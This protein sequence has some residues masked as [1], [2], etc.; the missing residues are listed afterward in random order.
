MYHLL[1]ILIFLCGCRELTKAGYAALNVPV[2]KRVEK[3]RLIPRN[4]SYMRGL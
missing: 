1:K 4:A 3:R 2:K